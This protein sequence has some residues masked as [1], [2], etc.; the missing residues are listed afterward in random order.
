MSVSRYRSVA[1]MPPPP[2][3]TGEGLADRIRAVW[4]RARRLTPPAY[5]PGVHR[6][7]SVEAAQQARDQEVRARVRLIHCTSVNSGGPEK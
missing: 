6:Y 4:A 7:R 1:E 2:R 5:T 3:V